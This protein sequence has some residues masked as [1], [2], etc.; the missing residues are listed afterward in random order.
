[1]KPRPKSVVLDV[2]STLSR[3]SAPVRFLVAMGEIFGIDPN[4]TRVAIT[5]LVATGL[6]ERDERGA[7]RLGTAGAAIQGRV[8]SWRT[9]SSR[10][11]PWKG[12]WVG[13][14]AG[15]CQE[16]RSP[17]RR[18]LELVGMR[19]FSMGLWLRPENLAGGL[20]VLATSLRGLG[21]PSDRAIFTLHDLDE[22]AEV[23]A[24]KLWDADA[25]RQGYRSTIDVLEES[26]RRLE[27][28]EEQ[29]AMAESFLLGGAAI[30]QIVLDPLLPDAI[31]PTEERDA[32]VAVLKRYDELGRRIWAPFLR[33]FGVPAA[34]APMDQR[35][36]RTPSSIG[37]TINYGEVS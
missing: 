33:R 32:L 18:A 2:L 17:T 36:W 35:L 28:L 20:P 26:G 10:V 4:A 21:L 23:R 1:M 12:A 22:E 31:V 34:V 29:V 5:R 3:R 15:N 25:L 6:L 24:R 19:E 11:R 9:I 16:Q 13:V 27:Q 37:G 30:R 8:T 7:Y 14:A